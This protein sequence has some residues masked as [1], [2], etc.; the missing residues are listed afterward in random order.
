MGILSIII[1]SL[2]IC[3]L[4]GI[5]ICLWMLNNVSGRVDTIQGSVD[6]I[7]GSVDT[8]NETVED[9]KQLGRTKDSPIDQLFVKKVSHVSG[10]G[11]ASDVVITS[12][13]VIDFSTLST[14]K[15]YPVQFNAGY[16][17]VH[18]TVTGTDGRGAN[19]PNVANDCTLF[20]TIRG[21]GSSDHTPFCMVTMKAFTPSE[22]RF[23]GIFGTVLEW[24]STWIYM[25]GGFSYDVTS[26]NRVTGYPDGYSG[27]S[28]FPVV[29]EP[30]DETA[31]ANINGLIMMIDL[32]KRDSVTGGY[33]GT[34]TSFNRK[35]INMKSGGVEQVVFNNNL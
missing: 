18:F 9:V 4:I 14:D 33:D 24:N 28:S 21:G 2:T 3:C 12:R 6:T 17:P 10:N 7:N 35:I 8:I 30:T 1:Q 11:E 13:K 32:A 16:E 19:E 26:S 15:F 31:A 23:L 34:Y 27:K 25:R 5:G 20:G 29:P 22:N